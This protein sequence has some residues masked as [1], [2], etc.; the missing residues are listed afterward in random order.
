[1]C[2]CVC[3]VPRKKKEANKKPKSRVISL[4]SMKKKSDKKTMKIYIYKIIILELI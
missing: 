3:V 1:M 2:M 4:N